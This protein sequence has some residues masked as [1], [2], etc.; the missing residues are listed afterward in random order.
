MKQ[1]MSIQDLARELERQKTAKKDYLSDTRELSFHSVAIS[2]FGPSSSLKVG[3]FEP[4]QVS[5]NFHRQL[6][7]RLQIPAKYYD[8]LRKDFPNLLD[9]NVNYLF[10]NAP[11]RRMVRTLDGQARA[12][13][14]DRYRV[15]DN[16]VVAEAALPIL[17]TL[18]DID[19]LSANISA[20]RFYLKVVNKRLM[21]EVKKGDVVQAGIVLSNS[22]VGLGAFKV[23]PLVYRLVC[24]N[25]AIA[26]SLANSSYHVGKRAAE[27]D[28]AYEL[29]R[30]ETLKM[31]DRAFVL[32][33]QDLV[34]AAVNDVNG[35]NTI[36]GRWKEATEKK[37]EGNPVKAV[38][39]L[40]NKF[41]LTEFEQS[42]VLRHLIEGGDLSAYGL[43][44]AV[45]RT[46]QDVG[47]YD[48]ATE[49]E[50]FGAR[51]IELPG[52]EWAE[53]AEAA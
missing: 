3:N 38:E 40:S 24:L 42:G 45:T 26:A 15:L 16:E 9:E 21:Q 49:L 37:L 17:S 6:R 14:S 53:L 28:G 52:S 51:V 23:E 7:E 19:V 50:R 10:Q 33:V 11:E 43:L 32:K 4:V 1:G 20:E 31:D 36:I 12:F 39:V 18:P 44:N 13:L 2:K 8:L 46:A 30:D 34:R 5:E 25:G 22:E 35:F 27:Q 41:Q 47:E 29:Y 48:R